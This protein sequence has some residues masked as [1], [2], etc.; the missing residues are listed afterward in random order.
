LLQHFLPFA[1][2]LYLFIFATALG[3]ALAKYLNT[4]LKT[5][6]A[7]PWLVKL[8][9]D[10][11]LREGVSHYMENPEACPCTVE[12]FN[13]SHHSDHSPRNVSSHPELS[14]RLQ[15]INRI[16]LTPALKEHWTKAAEMRRLTFIIPLFQAPLHR[17]DYVQILRGGALNS[18]GL[19][20]ARS[21]APENSRC[22]ASKKQSSCRA[23]FLLCHLMPGNF[24]LRFLYNDLG[25]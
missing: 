3:S 22:V 16:E 5:H 8:Q 24:V 17:S 7:Q 21:A 11:T 12:L 14:S 20:I 1:T 25:S 2:K 15:G 9:R 23:R 6:D 18:I 4:F 19:S 13:T 10:P